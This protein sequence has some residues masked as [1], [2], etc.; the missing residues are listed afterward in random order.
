MHAVSSRAQTLNIIKY[1]LRDAQAF[2]AKLFYGIRDNQVIILLLIVW[3]Q[4]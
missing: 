3:R 4:S 2:V 1:T